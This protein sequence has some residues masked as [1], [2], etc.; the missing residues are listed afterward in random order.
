[1]SQAL[2]RWFHSDGTLLYVGVS[3]SIH[4]R[5]KQHEKSAEWFSQAAFMTVEWFA[6]RFEVERAE[7]QAIKNESPIY[8]KALSSIGGVALQITPPDSSGRLRRIEQS[9][10]FYKIQYQRQEVLDSRW[11]EH[12]ESWKKLHNYSKENV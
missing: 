10:Q 2:Y 12:L 7:S 9:L 8:N 3:G 1:M 6:N 5:V 4:K 11:Q